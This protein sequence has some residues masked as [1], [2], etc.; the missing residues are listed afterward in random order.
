M[1]IIYNI[2]ERVYARTQGET[3]RGRMGTESQKEQA[4]TKKEQA[5]VLAPWRKR[6]IPG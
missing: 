6:D 2:K 5:R 4:E 3:W 1:R